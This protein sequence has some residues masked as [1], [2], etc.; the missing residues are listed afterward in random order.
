MLDIKQVTVEEIPYFYE[1]ATCR[2]EPQ[3]IGDAMGKT[4]QS[5][6]EFMQSS[7]IDGTG[8]VM[9]V[10]H[11]YDP[12]MMTF[13]AGFSVAP[14]DAGKAQAPVCYDTTPA[15]T[16]IHFQHKG[17]YSKLQDSYVEMA[18]HLQREGLKTASPCW[19]VYLNDPFVTPED[20][21]LTDVF[22]S[23]EKG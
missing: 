15:G 20:E 1:E 8:K 22:V 18:A 2:M 6:W 14:G 10:Y 11:T 16:V 5:V 12:Q 13:R 3:E 4:F 7:G 19:E 23:F 17:A 9:A 21:L